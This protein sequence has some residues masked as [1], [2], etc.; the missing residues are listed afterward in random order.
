MA[1]HVPHLFRRTVVLVSFDGLR[2][3][4]ELNIVQCVQRSVS[5]VDDSWRH[6]SGSILNQP[7]SVAYYM[8]GN[9]VHTTG[10]K[11][12]FIRRAC[13]RAISSRF[14]YAR[15]RSLGPDVIELSDE[16]TRRGDDEDGAVDSILDTHAQG[17]AKWL[18]SGTGA[19]CVFSG[20]NSQAH[21]VSKTESSS[22]YTRTTF[23]KMALSPSSSNV[24]GVTPA[25]MSAPVRPSPDTRVHGAFASDADSRVMNNRAETG[26]ESCNPTKYKDMLNNEQLSVHRD[27]YV[28]ARLCCN[29]LRALALCKHMRIR[30]AM[31]V[32]NT[33]EPRIMNPMKIR[34]GAIRIAAMMS[35]M[36]DKKQTNKH[37]RK[38]R[39]TAMEAKRKRRQDPAPLKMRA[40]VHVDFPVVP[41]DRVHVASDPSWVT[42][43]TTTINTW[44]D[45]SS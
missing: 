44:Q 43:P 45:T 26:R 24:C 23:T 15:F 37:G 19:A 13:L 30:N 42:T 4:V 9:L 10:S 2:N 25:K 34:G 22:Q 41:I 3:E 29:L 21:D 12:L 6:N 33:S 27:G 36:L 8:S 1:V 31:K 20:Q 17:H 11:A 38:P 39:A 40:A 18:R 7:S 16:V 35:T 14:Q 32:K 5:T 28:N